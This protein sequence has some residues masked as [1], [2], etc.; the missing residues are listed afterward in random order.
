MP[1]DTTEA[2]QW[3][4]PSWGQFFKVIFILAL[5]VVMIWL[6]LALLRRVMGFKGTSVGNTKLLGGIPMGTRK[7]LQFVMIGN[8]L[9]VLGVTDHHI[10]LLSTIED[11][12][13][14]EAILDRSSQKFDGEQFTRFL[15]KFLNRTE[16]AAE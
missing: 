9:H 14:I 7:S 2:F 8:T 16:N 11:P 6:T 5:V 3:I 13:K 10:S 1:I 4:E 12:D 15:K